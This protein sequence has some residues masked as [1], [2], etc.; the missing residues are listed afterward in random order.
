MMTARPQHDLNGFV[1]GFVIGGIVGAG[2]AIRWAPRQA[3]G[4]RRR[5][6]DAAADIG[7]VA[8][9]R[10]QDV[11]GRVSDTIDAF[12]SS[13]GAVRDDVADAV[14]RGARELEQFATASKRRARS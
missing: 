2:V 8:T 13:A 7:G 10:C 5:V 3:A 11:S 6:A 1:L 9:G 12:T 4:L 14:A